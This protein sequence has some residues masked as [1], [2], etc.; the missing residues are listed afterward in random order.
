MPGSTVTSEQTRLVADHII[1]FKDSAPVDCTGTSANRGVIFKRFLKD[2]LNLRN[3][4]HR[5]DQFDVWLIIY[6]VIMKIQLLNTFCQPIPCQVHLKACPTRAILPII[7]FIFLLVSFESMS[8]NAQSFISVNVTSLMSSTV[9]NTSCI[10]SFIR[11]KLF[12]M[13]S[14]MRIN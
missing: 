13:A 14:K 8:A 12:N 7:R 4:H 1:L 6:T 10:N 11:P 9:Y 3:K 2:L 5:I